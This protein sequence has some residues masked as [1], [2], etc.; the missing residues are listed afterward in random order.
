MWSTSYSNEL[1]RL[2]Q[3]VGSGTSGPQKKCVK[4]TDTF[5][6]IKFDD[7]P[8]YHWKE[9]YHTSVVCE[10]RSNKD[11]PRFTCI[12]VAGTRICY[13]G[14]VATPTGSLELLNLII[15]GVIS[16]PGERFACFDIKTHTWVLIWT[17][18]NMQG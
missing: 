8:Q 15:N 10:V 6:V 12:T 16:R 7:I 11:Y 5:R 2:C 13:P 1:R 4:G 9:I 14:D 3:G 17:A 18:Q